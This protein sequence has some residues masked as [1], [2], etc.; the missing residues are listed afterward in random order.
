MGAICR[1]IR[2]SA[3]RRIIC[4]SDIHGHLEF[5]KR[6]LDKVGYV[7]GDQL[8]LLGD[9]YTKGPRCHET[10]KYIIRMAENPNVHVLR[11]NCD[12]GANYL[13]PEEE[14]WQ[15][16]LPNIIETEDYIFVHG[17]LPS[18]DYGSFEPIACM[19]Y[20]N[21]MER[22]G[23]FDKWVVT[24][25]WPVNNYCH[26]IVCA[27][28]IVNTEKHIIAID[29]GCVVCGHGG[30]LNALLIENGAFSFAAVDDF[31]P[32]R[33]THAQKA[34]GGT[35]SLTFTDR[36]V[37]VVEPGEVFSLCRHLA[38]GRE[39]E[40]PNECLW[41]DGAGR[42]G[43]GSVAT[44]YFLPVEEGET[45]SLVRDYGS[46]VLAKRGGVIGWITVS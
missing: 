22:A 45:V 37:E 3:D 2:L 20:D 46:R 43:A 38:T 19:K 31:P 24:G 12:W 44:D 26:R 27:N 33:V 7:P 18:M 4:I 10:L 41:R 21:F 39:I 30:Q 25:H 14:A 13:T 34:S 16:A 42:L 11:G 29:G 32:Y 17:G 1:Q 9:L 15:D 23:R 5:F 6:L 28:P 40:V 35:L 36:F 8:I